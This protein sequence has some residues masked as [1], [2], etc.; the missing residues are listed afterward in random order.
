MEKLERIYDFLKY[1]APLELCESWD[2]SGLLIN[3]NEN[4]ENV[5][6]TL[7][8]TNS[9]INEAIN[10]NCQLIISHHPVIFKPLKN[11]NSND[12][13]F[14]LIE[15]NISV[16]SMHTNLDAAKG[17]VNDVLANELGL[18]NIKEFETIGRCGWI[19]TST[20]ETFAKT[21]AEILNT[22][23]KYTLPNKEINSIAVIG[24]SAG[25]YWKKVY[26]LGIDLFVTGEASHHDA[27][28]SAH[29]G[30]GL[31]IG[32]HWNT[33]AIIRK[34][35]KSDCERKFPNISFIISETDCEPF[36]YMV[37]S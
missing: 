12:L 5:L 3:A 29:V 23:V 8:I 18:L 13:V 32:G 4:I 16:I 11:I 24:G 37:S 9:V 1:K 17:G 6:I 26:E 22:N 2:N 31:I 19:P 34:Q 27:I 33:E 7:D 21:V 10:K 35:I 25:S 15:N 14:K 28:D 30:V 20:V 36:I